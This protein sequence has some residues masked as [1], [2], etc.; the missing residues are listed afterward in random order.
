[1]TTEARWAHFG[2]CNNAMRESARRGNTPIK[3]PLEDRSLI[4][5]PQ[6]RRWNYK[7]EIM[8]REAYM[9]AMSHRKRD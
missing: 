1:M 8:G 6:Q 5:Y 3:L 9:E 4:M 2:P 7:K